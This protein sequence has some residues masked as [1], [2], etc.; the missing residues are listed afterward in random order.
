MLLKCKPQHVPRGRHLSMLYMD[1]RYVL[2]LDVSA[3]GE[4]K[5]A[6]LIF[7]LGVDSSPPSLSCRERQVI[8]LSAKVIPPT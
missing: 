2:K 3:S 4:S 1:V 8:V 6:V 5:G 7:G